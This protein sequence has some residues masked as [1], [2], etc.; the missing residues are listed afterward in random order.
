[1]DKPI[2]VGGVTPTPGN[3]LISFKGLSLESC[4]FTNNLA[5]DKR[6]LALL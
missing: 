4:C 2:N 5:D 1:M 6:F 3:F